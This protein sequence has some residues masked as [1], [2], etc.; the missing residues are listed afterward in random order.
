MEANDLDLGDE[1]GDH[2]GDKFGDFGDKRKDLKNAGIFSISLLLVKIY[3]IYYMV[4]CDVTSC[5]E[6]YKNPGVAEMRQSSLNFCGVRRISLETSSLCELVSCETLSAIVR[7]IAVIVRDFLSARCL[8]YASAVFIVTCGSCLPE[9]SR[10][11]RHSPLTCLL[12][13]FHHTHTER[14]S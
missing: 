2:F 14:I 11:K 6:R 10:I 3:R 4:L 7:T 12:N 13:S 1:L 5:E 9:Y 8:I